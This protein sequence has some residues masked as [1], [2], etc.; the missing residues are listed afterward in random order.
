MVLCETRR[1]ECS[2]SRYAAPPIF[3]F[4]LTAMSSAPTASISLRTEC[5]TTTNFDLS[6]SPFSYN[7]LIHL[8]LGVNTNRIKLTRGSGRAGTIISE[9][10]SLHDPFHEVKSST[11]ALQ[12]LVVMLLSTR[13][14]EER[15]VFVYVDGLDVCKAC[16]MRQFANGPGARPQ[17]SSCRPTLCKDCRTLLVGQI[18]EE[19]TCLVVILT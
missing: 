5:R 10:T 3:L 1:L 4:A 14:D 13:L 8:F 17:V 7:P 19:S 18:N 9:A 15:A 11:F 16:R 12:R 2:W 6:T